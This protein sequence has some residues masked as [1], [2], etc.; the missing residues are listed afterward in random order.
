MNDINGK[1]SYKGREYKLV[2]NLNV[3]EVIQEEYGTIEKWGE[4]TD[5]TLTGEG[6]AKAVKFGFAAMLNEGIAI[7]NEDNGTDIKPFTL[8]QVGRMLTEIGLD[9]A[10]GVLNQTVIES[11]K[12]EEKNA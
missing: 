8:A 1:I 4:L 11:T 12:S 10:T 9:T 5:G 7:D 3:M 2:F 6:N